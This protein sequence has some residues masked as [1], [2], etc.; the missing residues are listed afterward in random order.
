MANGIF[1]LAATGYWLLI[2]AKFLIIK[3]YNRLATFIVIT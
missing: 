1:F 3:M 2:L